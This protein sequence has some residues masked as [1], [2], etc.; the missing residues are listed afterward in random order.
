MTIKV[1]DRYA[2]RANP[3]DANY[4]HGS[5]KNESV[6]GADDGTP[7]E[8]AQA[9][10]TL[11]ASD[12]ILLEGNI[13]ASGLPDTRVDSQLLQSLHNIF[14]T[15]STSA[16]MASGIYN[17]NRSV[18]IND[19]DS[20]I[21]SVKSSSNLVDTFFNVSAGSN[22]AVRETRDQ[23]IASAGTGVGKNVM[24]QLNLNVRDAYIL[25]ETD[26]T[27]VGLSRWPYLSAIE[28]GS[29]FPAYTVLFYNWNHA[30]DTYTSPS[31]VSVGTGPNTLHWY[32]GEQSG[33]TIAYFL[34]SRRPNVYANRNFDLIVQNYGHNQQIGIPGMADSI[35][36]NNLIY[37]NIEAMSQLVQDQ[38]DAE[39]AITLQNIDTS[40]AVFTN[41]QVEA[42]LI[43]AKRLG[44]GIIDARSV[45][46]WK[47]STGTI[48]DWMVDPTHPNDVGSR[49]WTR[50]F[51]DSLRSPIKTSGA[52]VNTLA[53]LTY[54][55]I[56]NPRFVVWDINTDL[57]FG[58]M[59]SVNA[60]VSRS[61]VQNETG[62]YCVSVTSSDGSDCFIEF[63]LSD[64]IKS[65]GKKNPVTFA[66]RIFTPSTN[67]TES[68][69]KVFI[70]S[71]IAG[72]STGEYPEVRDGWVWRMVTI[73]TKDIG[74]STSLVASINCGNNTD[75]LYIDRVICVDGRL[76]KDSEIADEFFPD[77]YYPSNVGSNGTNVITVSGD[78]VTMVSTSEANPQ[79]YIN[80]F[81]LVPGAS[82]KIASDSTEPTGGIL[83]RDGL[84]DTGVVFNQ[85]TG[86]GVDLI[87]TPPNREC[88][89]Q[90]FSGLGTTPFT[91]SNIKIVRQ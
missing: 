52:N 68:A 50:V 40:V 66:A 38:P 82:Y 1:Y 49:V 43:A 22:T 46:S 73:E 83:A 24:Q 39:I 59:K 12:A 3:A 86:L 37:R 51:I 65:S 71:S 61:N 14:D 56:K 6:P 30:T 64:Y 2:P 88:S 91:V 35:R 69:G 72:V 41:Q 21:Y 9:N 74:N 44:L 75:Q 26:S 63:N 87:F 84:N 80:V 34:G 45:F 79:F 53:E 70:N 18:T 89:L 90:V 10:D 29:M 31:T 25:V 20:N 13:I 28:L 36:L 15:T 47:N 42:N 81:G 54:N 32:N 5:F 27:G 78:S 16:R 23:Y 58:L 7:L 19:L 60:N 55:P 33:S 57:P 85:V 76:I 8:V 11:G 4:T 77:Y 48:G 67:S 17:I 62:N